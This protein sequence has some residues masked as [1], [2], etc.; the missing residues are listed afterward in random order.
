MN[1]ALAW[2]FEMTISTLSCFVVGQNQEVCEGCPVAEARVTGLRTQSRITL[3]RRDVVY[4]VTAFPCVSGKEDA[5][6]GQQRFV[7][8][9][10]D[11]THEDRKRRT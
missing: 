4:A 9:Y 10:R 8:T 1:M 7:C 2:L 3:A 5:H 6:S 11:I